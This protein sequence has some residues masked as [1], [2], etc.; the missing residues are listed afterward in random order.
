MDGGYVSG[1]RIEVEVRIESVP[2]LEYELPSGRHMH[3]RLDSVVN[4][5]KTV[6]I[7]NTV[8]AG[9][10]NNQRRRAFDVAGIGERDARGPGKNEGSHRHSQ[11]G[12][13]FHWMYSM[14]LLASD[15]SRRDAGGLGYCI[16]LYVS[17]PTSLLGRSGLPAVE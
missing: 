2:R 9:L 10:G 7:I 14:R 5:V 6:R 17:A 13:G 4:T 1:C 3:H 11:N 15:A 16:L 8:L 12:L